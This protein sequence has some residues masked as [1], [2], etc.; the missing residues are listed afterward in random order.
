MLNFS[1][2]AQIIVAVIFGLYFVA[3]NLKIIPLPSHP[4]AARAQNKTASAQPQNPAD[5]TSNPQAQAVYEEFASMTGGTDKE[6]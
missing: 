5:G 1:T 6:T 2:F 3:P 4:I